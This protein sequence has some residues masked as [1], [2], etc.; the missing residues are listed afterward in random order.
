MWSL[1][2][3]KYLI[4]LYSPFLWYCEVVQCPHDEMKQGEWLRLCD[5]V[6]GY[7]WPSDLTSEG[8]F[9]YFRTEV[10]CGH[11]KE[12]VESKTADEGTLLDCVSGRAGQVQGHRT[13]LGLL[14][15]HLGRSSSLLGLLMYFNRPDTSA[16]IPCCI[17]LCREPGPRVCGIA[18]RST[19]Q[20]NGAPV[21]SLTLQLVWHLTDARSG[22]VSL[23]LFKYPVV[24]REFALWCTA[25]E[26]RP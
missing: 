11:R 26:P 15:W 17:W 4:V 13:S 24:G 7:A 14:L 16:L 20:S 18:E 3:S 21:S 22:C 19:G 23:T 6:F 9:R 5:V 2:L 1:S 25:W 12:T 10:D 8:G